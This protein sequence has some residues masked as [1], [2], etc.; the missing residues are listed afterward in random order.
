MDK[1]KSL[2]RIAHT[3]SGSVAALFFFVLGLSGA[4]IVYEEE[5]LKVA[6]PT[7]AVPAE[8]DVIAGV[9]AIVA[10]IGAKRIAGMKTPDE[11]FFGYRVG[12]KNGRT[13][14]LDAQGRRLASI[15]PFSSVTRTLVELHHNWLTGKPGK[16]A[17][18]VLAALL[19]IFICSG[20]LLWRKRGFKWRFLAPKKFSP[21]DLH[22]LH[23]NLGVLISPLLAITALTAFGIV[24]SAQVGP[25]FARM[26]PAGPVSP[27]AAQPAA[28]GS[29]PDAMR[30]AAAIFPDAAFVQIQP[31]AK[32]G[33]VHKISMKRPGE[34]ANKG[35]TRV[36]VSSADGSIELARD[37]LAGSWNAKLMESLLPLHSG[38]TGWFGHKLIAALEGVLLSALAAAGFFSFWMRRMRAK[39][40]GER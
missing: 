19:F 39:G 20:W 40:S 26:A 10:E 32:P 7:L 22:A 2:I 30:A 21:P 6:H 24:F 9:D 8:I 5:M 25:V 15:E 35:F 3:F 14:L 33:A 12:L 4:A 28:S 18:G 36:Y 31:A 11:H 27:I 1:F 29:L 37:A 17:N 38:H 13:L 23:R 16:I 34:I